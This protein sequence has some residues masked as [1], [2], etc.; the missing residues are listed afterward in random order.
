VVVASRI[1]DTSSLVAMEAAACGVPVLALRHGALPEIVA[2][3]ES[4]W[5]GDSVAELA[6][7]AARLDAIEAAAC[8]ARA[9]RLFDGRRMAREYA[10]LYARLAA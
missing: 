3:G 7:A 5:L 1:A 10:S 4:G 9:E 6:D 2:Q 8:R